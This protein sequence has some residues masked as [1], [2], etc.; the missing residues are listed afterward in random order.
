MAKKKRHNRRITFSPKSLLDQ[1]KTAAAIRL[2]E[3][4]SK[5]FPLKR[6]LG[7][8]DL[9]ISAD[10]LANAIVLTGT[11]PNAGDIKGFSAPVGRRIL[12]TPHPVKVYGRVWKTISNKTAVG[13]MGIYARPSEVYG[14]KRIELGYY[15]IKEGR[16]I[17][18]YGLTREGDAL[19]AF[20]LDVVTWLCEEQRAETDRIIAE[21]F[22]EV[23]RRQRQNS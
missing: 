22:S 17:R 11:I 10:D 1:W 4:A 9:Y 18:A 5:H 7:G 15:G 19:P 8:R 20:S 3:F 21:C 6:K 14:G 23:F 2:W 13:N 12:A 16:S